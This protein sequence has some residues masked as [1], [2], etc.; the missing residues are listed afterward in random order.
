MALVRR[1]RDLDCGFRRAAEA[2]AAGA[3]ERSELDRSARTRGSLTNVDDAQPQARLLADWDH[4]P[5]S[6]RAPSA[7]PGL[8]CRRSGRVDRAGSGR[9]GVRDAGFAHEEKQLESLAPPRFAGD[10][11]EYPS[12]RIQADPAAELKKMK[13]EDLGRLNIRLDRSQGGG[14]PHS[15]RPRDRDPRARRGF[16][17][18]QERGVTPGEP[19]E[20]KWSPDRKEPAKAGAR[21]EPKP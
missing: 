7:G 18:P 4:R 19:A 14:C 13:A 2:A 3:A 8:V 11:G 17:L 9:A 16:R 20:K 12:P 15:G 5:R 21:A 10:T 6:Q 1:G